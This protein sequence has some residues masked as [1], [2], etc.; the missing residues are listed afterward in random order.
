MSLTSQE[1]LRFP[2]SGMICGTCVGRITRALRRLDGVAAVRVNLADETVAV[3]RDPRLAPDPAIV[4]ALAE[5]GYEAHLDAAVPVAPDL[6]SRGLL[7][8]I[9]GR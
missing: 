7:S 5:A 6:G 3:R 8:R 9:L 4:A 1:A 2:V